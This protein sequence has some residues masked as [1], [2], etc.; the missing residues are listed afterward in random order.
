MPAYTF[1]VPRAFRFDAGCVG[2]PEVPENDAFREQLETKVGTEASHRSKDNADLQEI[3]SRPA[4]PSSLSLTSLAHALCAILTL[5]GVGGAGHIAP[6][7][8]A[9]GE[10]GPLVFA[11]AG[12]SGGVRATRR[13]MSR[14]N[15]SVAHPLV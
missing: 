15:R 13:Q 7:A 2:G 8:R 1:D 5:G 12:A 11:R 14:D 3:V 10:M 9:G 4:F 6:C